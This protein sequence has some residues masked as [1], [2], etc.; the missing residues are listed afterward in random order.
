LHYAT[1][2]SGTQVD[3]DSVVQLGRVDVAGVLDKYFLFQHPK[4]PKGTKVPAN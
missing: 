4:I 2:D 1:K 3:G